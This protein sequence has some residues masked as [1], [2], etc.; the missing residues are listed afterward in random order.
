MVIVFERVWCLHKSNGKYEAPEAQAKHFARKKLRYTSYSNAS[1]IKSKFIELKHQVEQDN[2]VLIS[3]VNAFH[4][5]TGC[6]ITLL[7]L[8]STMKS[9]LSGIL[10]Q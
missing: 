2:T 10:F 9:C 7:L 8:P 5:F 1:L 4:R 6:A 3:F